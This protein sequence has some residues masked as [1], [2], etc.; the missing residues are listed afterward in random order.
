MR[1]FLHDL[2]GQLGIGMCPDVD[3]LVVTFVVGDET[4]IVVA[5]H[6]VDFLVGF[7]DKRFLDLRDDHI[8]EVEGQPA[9]ESHDEPEV[10]DIIE[11]IG[12]LLG[13]GCFQDV[14][15]DVA[16]GLLG[17][18]LVDVTHLF[19]YDLVEEDP[20]AGGFNDLVHRLAIDPV[21]RPSP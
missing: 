19:R 20:S 16:E 13:T 15:D 8:A 5:Q 2:L 18:Q 7:V 12:S 21:I 9:L 3:D 6:F 1:E 11:E 10:L 14:P 17:E 4:H